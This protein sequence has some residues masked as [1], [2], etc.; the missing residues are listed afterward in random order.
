MSNVKFR[1]SGVALITP[2]KNDRSIDFD[3]LGKLIDYCINGGIE[4]LVSLGTTGESV[5]L[6]KEE[7][8][9]VLEFTV[10]YA[11]GRVPVVAGFGGNS[12]HAVIKDIEAFH[13]NGVDAVLS[14]SPY[15]NKPT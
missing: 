13:F 12:T 15:Y 3:A 6:T 8:R 10:K 4:Y 2:F 9:E 5:N 14:V 11:N 1:G 7:K